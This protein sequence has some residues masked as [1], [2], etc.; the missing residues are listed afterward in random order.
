M[1]T[2]PDNLLAAFPDISWQNQSS[3][4]RLRFV[5][6]LGQDGDVGQEALVYI[7]GNDEE[8]RVRS[9]AVEFISQL[10]TLELM[11]AEPGLLQDALNHQFYRVLSGSF[12]STATEAERLTIIKKLDAAALKQ[13]ALLSKCKAAGSAALLAI[14]EP[15][16]IADLCLFA[17]SVHVRKNAALKL[18]DK[19]LIQEI[20]QKVEGKDKTVHKVLEKLL[21]E[22][23][24]PDVSP[25]KKSADA[26]PKD[27]QKKTSESKAQTK[28][29]K[30]DAK[31]PKKIK[32]PEQE[33]LRLTAELNKL[34]PKNTD[35]LHALKGSI[36][37]LSQ[38]G[39]SELKTIEGKVQTLQKEL[40]IKLDRNLNHQEQLKQNTLALLETLKQAL[41][42]GQSH[43]ALP[44][45][46]KIQGNI[47]NMQGKL[48]STLQAQ[49]NIYKAKLT[50]LRDWKSFAATEK[51]KELITQMQHLLDSK[52]HAGDRSKHIG[53]LHR[54]WKEL[55]RS[56]QN[57]EL[58]RKFK[59]ISDQAYEP[60][61]A[62]FKQRKQDMAENLQK[63]REICKKLEAE[64]ENIAKENINI[65]SINKLLS[66]SE[67]DWKTYA[68]VDQS[69][70]K[71]LQKNYY[72]VVNQLRRLRRN[73]LKQNGK[74][75]QSLIEQAQELANLEDNKKAMEEAKRLQ[76]EW[77]KHGPTSYKE[78]KKYW[79]N[80]RAACDKVFEKRTQQSAKIQ[81]DIK[82]AEKK[83]EAILNS[84]EN[85]L[86]LE[87]EEFRA[88][89]KDFNSLVQD[90]AASLDP[91][92]KK[93]RNRWLDQFNGVKRKIEQRFKAL[94]D[95]KHLKLKNALLTKASFCSALESKLLGSENDEKLSQISAQFDKEAWEGLETSGNIEYEKAMEER[96]QQVSKAKS[97]RTLE[98]ILKES[99]SKLRSLCIELEIRANI[100]SP[101][102]DQSHR[103][104]IQLDQ[105][106][107]GFGQS[108][109]SREENVKY[110]FDAELKSL[111]LGPIAVDAQ[112]HLS[113]RI[114]QAI[115][116]L[117]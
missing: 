35:K 16:D 40:Q 24:K 41:E 37:R 52:M 90:F 70:I 59:T 75:K 73:S 5:Q 88:A 56:N 109:P 2:L 58:W 45:W 72:G 22:P 108:K 94:P 18:T 8:L 67:K 7:A 48:R 15:A 9:R 12:N 21:Q 86:G 89:R 64:L 98:T 87:D 29:K 82:A 110:A 34:S 83:L 30:V 61:K 46:D 26:K 96:V 102:E 103:M 27:T 57:E 112:K 117:I 11:R 17:A 107:N 111:C 25:A 106:K 33:L 91:R 20:A 54:K 28:T 1:A 66:Q 77:K 69:K 36:N 49:T 13:V 81:D 31:G 63:R 60:C 85:T 6:K 14:Q 32:N 3:T 76:Q 19:T 95:K 38:L 53:D 42:S 92:I 51:K 99:E 105:L 80:F 79:D 114:S 104:Q 43:D 4:K 71:T 113:G 101:K 68:P 44:A 100:E 23:S 10:P 47:S 62:Y 50:E 78:D 93:Q 84:L 55:G 65:S 97:L 74:E 39:E 115:D 116:K